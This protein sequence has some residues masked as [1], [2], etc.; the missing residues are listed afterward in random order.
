MLRVATARPSARATP[1]HFDS[2]FC[3]DTYAPGCRPTTP[4][5]RHLARCPGTPGELLADTPSRLISTGCSGDTAWS[6]RRGC[7]PPGASRPGQ[8]LST[9]DPAAADALS[10]S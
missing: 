2:A 10:G 9:L 5:V 7:S 8:R 4:L 6:C 1:G 3:S